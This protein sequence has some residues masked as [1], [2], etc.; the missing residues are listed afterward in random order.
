MPEQDKPEDKPWF[1]VKDGVVHLGGST[2][3]L[4]EFDGVEMIEEEFKEKEEPPEEEPEE[5][6]EEPEEVPPEEPEQKPEEVP[7]K[8]P[9]QTVPDEQTKYK[10]P[11]KFRGKE[12]VLE[13]TLKDIANQIQIKKSYEVNSQEMWDQK[14]KIDT[15][16]HIIDTPQFGEFLKEQTEQG[17]Y[18]PPEAPDPVVTYEIK[19]RQNP[20]VKDALVQWAE[21]NLDEEGYKIL[22]TTES[23]YIK[24][25]DRI[26]EEVRNASVRSA[27]EPSQKV[28]P[29]VEE[30]ILQAKEVAKS[31]AAVEKPGVKK[32]ITPETQR[33]KHRKTLEK[34]ARAGDEQALFELGKDLYFTDYGV[35]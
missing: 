9:E 1:E 12:E 32:D 13:L 29:K 2:L 30:K 4:G 11:I 26:A 35:E 33:K 17:V 31:R 15:Y 34:R 22:N 5:V 8:E 18:Q 10:V 28:D 14:R 16:A 25:Y 24:E 27:P 20:D 3:P 21:Q 23:V 6:A 7:P 19:K